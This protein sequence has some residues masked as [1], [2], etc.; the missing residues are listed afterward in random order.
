MGEFLLGLHALVRWLLVLV[1]IAAFVKIAIGL[2]RKSAYDKLAERLMIAFSGVA[3]LQ[4]LIGLILFVVLNSFS[5]G[6]RWEHA[7]VMTVAV[8]LS[9][10]HMRWK[11]APDATRYRA[12]L[13]IL[14]VVLVLVFIGVALLPQGWRLY[15][16]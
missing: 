6:Y 4:W 16:A 9:H 12:S 2:V 15:P 7:G 10:M 14:I 3:T 8:G 13:I 1:M 11:K 5:V